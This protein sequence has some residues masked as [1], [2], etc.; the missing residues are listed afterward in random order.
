MKK[1]YLV[2]HGETLFNHKYL[3]QGMCDSPLTEKG[4]MQAQQ[5]GQIFNEKGISFDPMSL[6]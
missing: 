2:R 4:H 3:I 6:S 1:L 5:A